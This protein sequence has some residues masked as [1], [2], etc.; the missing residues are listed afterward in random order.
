MNKGN[1]AHTARKKA[2][3]IFASLALP[4]VVAQA[5]GNIS[6]WLA[7]GIIGI[8]AAAH[9][10]WSA[11]LYSVSS[12]VFPKKVI[13][14]IVGIGSMA[15]AI[16]GILIAQTAGVLL[17][18]YKANSSIETGYYIMFLICGT[19]YLLAWFFM[20]QLVKEDEKV[21]I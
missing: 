1:T 17:D 14:S 5:A 7:I 10:A 20:N 4:V 21:I 6:M 3:L 8:A 15:G 9:Q 2:M 19:A 13:A 11:N 16:G 12:D 18:Y